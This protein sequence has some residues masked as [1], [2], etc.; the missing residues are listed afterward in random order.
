MSTGQIIIIGLGAILILSSLDFGSLF[1]TVTDNGKQPPKTVNPAIPTKKY[2]LVALVEKWSDLKDAC[3]KNG[4]TEAVSKLDEI[5]PT[6]I[7]TDK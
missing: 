5:F 1:K 6:L 3:E 7:K 4:L 2:E